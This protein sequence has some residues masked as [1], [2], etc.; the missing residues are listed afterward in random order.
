MSTIIRGLVWVVMMLALLA[1]GW[2]LLGKVNYDTQPTAEVPSRP[3]VLP[4]NE[5]DQALED[6]RQWA[7]THNTTDHRACK[8]ALGVG[9]RAMGCHRYVTAQKIIPPLVNN[10]LELPRTRDCVAAVHAH[11]DP[12]LQDMVELGDHHAASVRW[13]KTV[14]P[15]LQQCNNIDNV[16][17]LRD[18]DEPLG[19]LNA[20]VA[21]VRT[22]KSLSEADLIRLRREY[23]EVEQFRDDPMRTNYLATAQILFDLIGGRQ[24]VFP[25]ALSGVQNDAQC[26]KLTQ[27]MVEL[28]KAFHDSLERAANDATSS[29]LAASS[30]GSAEKI[31][32]AGRAK[33]L[34]GWYQT[35]EMLQKAGCVTLH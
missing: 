18:V 35:Q 27:Q 28:K 32:I 31:Q 2:H 8:D 30:L 1:A 13:R 34:A 33:V 10:G 25:L 3:T 11:W 15:L 4:V 24:Q 16:R 14:G 29:S 23:P 21:Q 22:G 20:M 12:R 5:A 19:R 26:A 9:Q 7:L 17:I 6:G